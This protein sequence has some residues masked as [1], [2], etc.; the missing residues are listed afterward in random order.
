MDSQSSLNPDAPSSR[1]ASSSVEEGPSLLDIEVHPMIRLAQATFLR[2][3]AELLKKHQH[4]WVAYHGDRRVA[5]G[6][7][8]RQLFQQCLSSGVPHGE[9]VVRFIEAETPDEIEW[10]EWRDV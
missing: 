8:K 4:R 6:K 9:F 2:D 7:S 5:I 10:N 3:L 1:E